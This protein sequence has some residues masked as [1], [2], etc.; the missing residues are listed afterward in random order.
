MKQFCISIAELLTT[1]TDAL[2]SNGMTPERRYKQNND[3]IYIT[4]Q[5]RYTLSPDRVKQSVSLLI[6][7]IFIKLSHRKS[8][9]LKI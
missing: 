3:S 2:M 1:R 4:R 5:P 7:L 6:T 8:Q 9:F